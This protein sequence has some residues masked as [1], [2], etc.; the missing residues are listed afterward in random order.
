MSATFN[1]MMIVGT[2]VLALLILASGAS[3]APSLGMAKGR[4]YYGSS[5]QQSGFAVTRS[6]AP[7]FSTETRQSYSYEPAEGVATGNG[8]MPSARRCTASR[9]E[10]YHQER[11]SRGT[12]G[13]APFVSYEPTIQPAPSVRSYNRIAA[14]AKDK[15]LY[16]K[17]DSRRY[18]H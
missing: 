12:K 1:K 17:S 11:R 10:R 4:P 15:W 5:N 3:A 6:Y 7:T 2:S 14:P 18:N 9:E 16:P 13:D 8:R